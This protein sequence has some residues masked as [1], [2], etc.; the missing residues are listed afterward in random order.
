MDRKS[1]EELRLDRRLF[2]RKNWLSPKDIEQEIEALPDVS[3]KIA[4]VTEEPGS[5]NADS[6]IADSSAPSQS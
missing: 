1:T 5:I 6:P 3:H 4:E 2:G